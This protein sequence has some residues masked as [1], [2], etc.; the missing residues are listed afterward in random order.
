MG[1][2]ERRKKGNGGGGDRR[3]EERGR[4]AGGG[5]ERKGKGGRARSEPGG[6]RQLGGGTRVGSHLRGRRLPPGVEAGGRRERLG[7]RLGRE[8]EGREGGDGD[9]EA[10]RSRRLAGAAGAATAGAAVA[11]AAGPAAAAGGPARGGRPGRGRAGR[12]RLGRRPVPAPG[13]LFRPVSGRPRHAAAR[14]GARVAAAAAATTPAARGRPPGRSHGPPEWRRPPGPRRPPCLRAVPT[15]LPGERRTLLGSSPPRGARGTRVGAT[16]DLA[17][18]GGYGAASFLAAAPWARPA[19]GMGT[20]GAERGAWTGLAALRSRWCPFLSL[21][22]SLQTRVGLPSRLRPV[23]YSIWVPRYPRSLPT[24]PRTVLQHP[25]PLSIA[26]PGL[27]SQSS[28]GSFPSCAQL[29]LFL[30]TNATRL[31][32]PFSSHPALMAPTVFCQ[33]TGR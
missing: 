10:G 33:R 24:R 28:R 32:P 1:E 5:K 19:P 25:P 8:A 2:E 6:G 14:R 16:G 20:R 13:D 12:W 22:E 30:S 7:G 31:D 21:P 11:A 26:R 27:P 4:G 9:W 29:R 18:R 23:P 17:T 15:L 3:E